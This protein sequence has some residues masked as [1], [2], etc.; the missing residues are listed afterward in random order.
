M[1]WTREFQL[2]NPDRLAEFASLA[3]EHRPGTYFQD[4]Q[5]G[6]EVLNAMVERA[7]GEDFQKF[8]QD[9]LVTPLGIR[10][11]NR[12]SM[13]DQAGHTGAVAF[14]PDATRR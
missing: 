2:R 6:P 12:Y 1:S 3:I 10:R 11:S 8:A 4:S 7:V 14:R 13:R 5:T 9:Q